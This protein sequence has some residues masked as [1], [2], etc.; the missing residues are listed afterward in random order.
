MGDPQTHPDTPSAVPAHSAS[1]SPRFRVGR[2]A[3]VFAVIAAV[4]AWISVV[5]T[6]W[7]MRR[8]VARYDYESVYTFPVITLGIV[9]VLDTLALILGLVG[10]RQPTA[11]A[12]SGAAI[13]IGATGIVGVFIYVIGTVVIMPRV[14]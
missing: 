4:L 1:T 10:V 3:L 5:V 11:K 7:A 9:L 14:G 8:A 13:G 12:V 2:A 6:P